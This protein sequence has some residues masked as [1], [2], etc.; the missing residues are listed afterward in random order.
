[1]N[2]NCPAGSVE[3]IIGGDF[4]R[5]ILATTVLSVS[6]ASSAPAF[7]DWGATTWGMSP[8][9]VVA[10]VP[11]AE[12]AEGKGEAVT[13][14]DTDTYWNSVTEMTEFE[15]L[16]VII[17]YLFKE[18]RGL[19]NV[20]IEISEEQKC[21]DLEASFQRRYGEG[22]T[23]VTDT[24]KMKFTTWDDPAKVDDWA[25]FAGLSATICSGRIKPFETAASADVPVEFAP[26]PEAT[27]DD[28][29]AMTIG[30]WRIEEEQSAFDDSTS[31]FAF[32]DPDSPRG[33]GIDKAELSMM[34]RCQENTTNVL[35][36]TSMFMIGDQAE[37]MYRI[38]GED[39]VVRRMSISANHKATGFW[40]GSEAIPFLRS[41]YSAEKLAVRVSDDTMVEGVFELAGIR[42]VTDRVAAACNWQVQ[43]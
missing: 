34:V 17:K 23:V 32:L 30:E 31:I 28:D 27:V 19:Q 36:S 7:A 9:D 22:K 2:S 39:A 5:S 14:G 13:Y 6:I 29:G 37:I 4:M 11:G 40:S 42:T 21:S 41:L 12:I 10:A 8:Q 1:M 33:T 18:S 25:Q 35:F 3:Q 24:Y 15:G 38:D 20:V 16:P 26:E 43:K